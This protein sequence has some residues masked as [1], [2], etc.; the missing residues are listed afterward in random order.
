[1]NPKTDGRIGG[2]RVPMP[3]CPPLT[4]R[5]LT[6]DQTLPCALTAVTFEGKEKVRKPLQTRTII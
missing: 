6:W 2:K 1:M 3:L 5:R 4:Q